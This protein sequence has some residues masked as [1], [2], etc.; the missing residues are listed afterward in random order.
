MTH[1][2][3]K[4][5][6]ALAGRYRFWSSSQDF[7]HTEDLRPRLVCGCKNMFLTA[8]DVELVRQMTLAEE[9]GLFG[10]TGKSCNFTINSDRSVYALPKR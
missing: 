6:T 10:V 3:R 9:S 1:G 8:N 5:L 2:P 4:Q 7:V